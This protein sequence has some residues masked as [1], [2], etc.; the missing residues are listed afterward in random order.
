MV[1]PIIL[2][3]A[4]YNGET[5]TTDYI[6]TTGGLNTDSTIYYVLTTATSTQ[7]TDT[8]LISQLNTLESAMSYDTQTNISQTND[9]L[10][11]IIS[12]SALM[13]GGN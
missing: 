6:S 1:K 7:I 5:I 3:I 8:T 2:K 13:K 11:F 12:A 4:S 10:P 9:D